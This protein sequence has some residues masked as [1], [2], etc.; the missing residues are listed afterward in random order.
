MRAKYRVAAQGFIQIFG[1]DNDETY[2]LVSQLTSLW[3][4]CVVAARN[5]WLIHQMD[6]YNAYVNADLEEPIY[7]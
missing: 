1:V 4:I 2:A 3:T 5:D 7:M 6:V